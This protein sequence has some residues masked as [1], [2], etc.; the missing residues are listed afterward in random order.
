MPSDTVADQSW[1]LVSLSSLRDSSARC[2]YI[3][4]CRL[5]RK[6]RMLN[7]CDDLDKKY[8]SELNWNRENAMYFDKEHERSNLYVSKHRCRNNEEA[9]E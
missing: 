7:F 8:L 3:I 1:L 4:P 5:R 6:L 9:L 2:F